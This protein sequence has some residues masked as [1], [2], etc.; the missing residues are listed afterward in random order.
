MKNIIAV[1]L[2]IV[3]GALFLLGMMLMHSDPTLDAPHNTGDGATQT[4]A[5][6]LMVA[7][8]GVGALAGM[9]SGQDSDSDKK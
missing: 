7:G 1:P 3:A 6:F 5:L 4:M 2:A 8:G 9:V